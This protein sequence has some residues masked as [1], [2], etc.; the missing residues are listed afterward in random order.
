MLSKVHSNI[1]LEK[2]EE[3]NGKYVNINGEWKLIEKLELEP[4]Q[5]IVYNI[6]VEE[7]HTFIANKFVVHNFEKKA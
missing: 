1:I 6:T 4:Y 2:L 5:G 7:T 3:I